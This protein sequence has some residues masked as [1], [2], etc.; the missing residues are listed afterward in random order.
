MNAAGGLS[1]PDIQRLADKI[2]KETFG[3]HLERAKAR[4]PAG[5]EQIASE[6]NDARNALLHWQRNRFSLPTYRG[7]DVTTYDGFAAC[8][9]D[10]L[11][12]VETVPFTA[13]TGD[14]R[15]SGGAT[16]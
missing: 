11:T 10:V 14:E 9:G 3:P 6:V 15:G 13:P 2:A 4:L 16:P 8:M 7:Q 1:L 12:F 5:M